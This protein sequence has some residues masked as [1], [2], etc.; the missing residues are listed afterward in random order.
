MSVCAKRI[1]KVWAKMRGRN[2]VQ[3]K[4]LISVFACWAVLCIGGILVK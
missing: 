3:F 2:Q 1:N 4:V